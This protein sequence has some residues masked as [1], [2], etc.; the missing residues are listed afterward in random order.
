[1]FLFISSKDLAWDKRLVALSEMWLWRLL[2]SLAMNYEINIEVI[3]QTSRAYVVDGFSLN[4][5]EFSVHFPE[6]ELM[7]GH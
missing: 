1:M 3:Q 2:Y 5:Q 4:V 7:L 6:F